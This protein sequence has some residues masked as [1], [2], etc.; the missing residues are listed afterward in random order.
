[1]G[2]E[3]IRPEP[4]SRM[5]MTWTLGS[6]ENL[7]ILEFGSMGH[8][9]YQEKH[10][11]KLPVKTRGVFYSTHIDEKDIAL[12]ISERIQKAI[13]K[14]Q[15]NPNIKAIA[16]I[17]SSIGEIIGIDYK[18]ILLEIEEVGGIRLPIFTLDKGGF[19]YTYSDGVEEAL[20]KL[21]TTLTVLDHYHITPKQ[22]SY[23]VIG[24]CWNDINI[25]ERLEQVRKIMRKEGY[26]EA[27]A[28]LTAN[29]CVEK[30]KKIKE[31]EINIVISP[32]GVKT[33]RWLK[34]YLNMPYM[35]PGT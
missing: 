20:Y 4:S 5:G 26:K 13:C 19:Q 27:I 6:V 16:L 32:E 2:L 3:K 10:M 33:A 35:V 11:S 18:S 7:A 14:I 28:I 17:P 31:A 12:G 25:L 15:N 21:V 8:T 23:N 22:G 24:A 1:M 9:I 34:K 29:T 30:I